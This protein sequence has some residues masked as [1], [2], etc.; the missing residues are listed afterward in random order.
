MKYKKILKSYIKIC[1]D[2]LT[3]FKPI[4]EKY[5]RVF[6]DILNK[7]LISDK[8][9]LDLI[10]TAVEIFNES[11]PFEYDSFLSDLILKEEEKAFEINEVEKKFLNS[12]LNL[13]GAVKYISDEENLPLNL[14]RLVMIEKNRE[15]SPVSLRR[16]YSLLYPVEKVI[17]CEGA[18]EEILLSKF[19]GDL[20]C[21]FNKEGILV[22]GAGGKNQVARKYY[23]MV[24]NI[25]IPVFILLDFDA[26]ET[27]DI[28]KP[29][30]RKKDKIYLIKA[31]EFEDIL[32]KELI[33]DSINFNFS[34]NLHCRIE[35]FN[36]DLKMTKNLHNVFKNKGFG[37]YKKAD[38]AK[39]VK[40]YLENNPNSVQKRY[41]T[42]EIEEIISEIKGL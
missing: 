25:K 18:T 30:L 41:L 14:K 34:N 29:K 10:K 2:R 12:G 8:K 4:S 13:S 1:I 22:L 3:R 35:D 11:V 28:I 21:D 40:N 17:L 9:G 6:L 26:V 32:S 20:G 16:E 15:I 39:M 5:E 19:A 23:K 38:F 7:H 33:V 42:P 27:V 31:G 36:Q 24:E 37:E